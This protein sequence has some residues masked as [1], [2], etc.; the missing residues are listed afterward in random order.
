ME[1]LRD[2]EVALQSTSDWIAAAPK[3]SSAMASRAVVH[4]RYGRKREALLDSK[5][6]SN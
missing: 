3:S 5:P 2:E 6:P 4:A 1:V